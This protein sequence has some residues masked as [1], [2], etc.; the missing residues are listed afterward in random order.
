MWD[1]LRYNER[2]VGGAFVLSIAVAFWVAMPASA[3]ARAPRRS[4]PPTQAA[5]Q[6]PEQS[7]PPADEV[8][9]PESQPEVDPVA[10]GEASPDEPVDYEEEA[11]AAPTV[12]DR[13]LQNRQ[14][15]TMV[16][17]FGHGLTVNDHETDPPATPVRVRVRP[18]GAGASLSFSVLF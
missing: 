13:V 15:R 3:L 1:R 14:V 5:E 6:P 9:A 7:P 11:E 16:S 8:E 17:L 2:M 10:V 4:L 12:T 18:K